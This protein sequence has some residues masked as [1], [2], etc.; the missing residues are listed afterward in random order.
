MK[1]LFVYVYNLSLLRQHFDHKHAVSCFL[2]HL[3]A[4]ETRLMRRSAVAPPSCLA[5]SYCLW[6]APPISCPITR[7]LLADC[8]YNIFLPTNST[9]FQIQS[10]ADNTWSSS[11][12]VTSFCHSTRLLVS[13]SRAMIHIWRR[14]W[15]SPE[16]CW[17]RLARREQYLDEDRTRFVPLLSWSWIAW[18]CSSHQ[19]RGSKTVLLD[20]ASLCISFAP[21]HCLSR[22]QLSKRGLAYT[23]DLEH[24][25]P[26]ARM[27]WSTYDLEHL[28]KVSFV[29]TPEDKEWSV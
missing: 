22:P 6:I 29:K 25:W 13:C 7:R 2:S 5:A 12:V 14:S 11:Q 15:T 18:G 28:F 20:K 9:S 8:K 10:F 3:V 26:G 16:I 19:Y 24:V 17:R 23:Y 27:I 21:A 1:L 4:G